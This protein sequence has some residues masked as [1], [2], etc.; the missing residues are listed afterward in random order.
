MEIDSW[1]L[2]AGLGFNIVVSLVGFVKLSVNYEHRFTRLE[3]EMS[4]LLNR[5]GHNE[6]S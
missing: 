2:L 4:I 6:R 5:S 1:I 3:T